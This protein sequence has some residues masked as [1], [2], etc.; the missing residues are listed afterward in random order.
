MR[1]TTT[2]LAV[3]SFAL[4]L[5]MVSCTPPPQPG[6]AEEQTAATESETQAT[7]ETPA[8]ETPTEEGFGEANLPDDWVEEVTLPPGAH[9]TEYS[10]TETSM[11]ASGYVEAPINRVFTFAS[12]ITNFPG[13]TQVRMEEWVRGGAM[14]K[15]FYNRPGM[16]LDITMTQDGDSKTLIVLDLTLE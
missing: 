12:D 10:K 14:R 9:V 13:W 4:I 11:H 2:L 6:P 1:L 16:N 5:Y 3:L 7:E 15:A 8:E